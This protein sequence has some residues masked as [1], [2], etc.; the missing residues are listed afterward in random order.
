REPRDFFS[1][2]IEAGVL[3]AERLENPGARKIGKRL[4]GKFLDEI[5]LHVDSNAVVPTR[6]GL[7]EQRQFAEIVDQ[8]LKRLARVEHDVL[9]VEP[10]H[11]IVL[12]DRVSKSGGVRHQ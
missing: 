9:A 12:I 1:G 6:S 3:H 4:T 10:I 7:A 8:V 5:T 2:H 11:W